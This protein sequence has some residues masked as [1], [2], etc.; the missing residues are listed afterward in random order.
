MPG[1]LLSPSLA[2]LRV[3]VG[4]GPPPVG[5]GL[6]NMLPKKLP[7]WAEALREAG[8]DT[9]GVRCIHTQSHDELRRANRA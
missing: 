1:A 4:L 6:P 7:P 9:G 3:P 8:C 2:S 5:L